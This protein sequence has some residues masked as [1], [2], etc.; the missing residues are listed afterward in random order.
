MHAVQQLH[1]V[2]SVSRNGGGRGRGA[3]RHRAIMRAI[4]WNAASGRWEMRRSADRAKD[5]TYFLFGLT[6]E[7]LVAHAVSPGRIRKAS[8]CASWRANWAFPPRKARQ[9]GNLFCPQR[10]LRRVHRRIFRGAG[11]CAV[12]NPRRAGDRRRPRGRRALRRAPFHG[13]PAAR[14]GRRRRRAAVR[15][16]DRARH[17]PRDR[18][19]Q[20]RAAARNDAREGYQL[21]LDRRAVRAAPRRNQ[22]SKQA[23][24]R[25]R[26]PIRPVDA[27]TVEVSFD[28]PQRAVTPGQGAVFYSGELVL[29]GGWIE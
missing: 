28:D 10:R 9:P 14:T 3:H 11:N 12:G 6:Q 1:Q 29:G 18:R 13:G 19:P 2:R 17:A 7:Q 27:T 8:R 23:R 16:L 26:P 4:T 22:D 5:Q 25:R 15:D 24:S 21:D 20:R